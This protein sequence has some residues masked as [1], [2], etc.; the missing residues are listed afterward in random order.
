MCELF[1]ITAERKIRVDGLLKTF[2]N[3]SEKHRN[4]WGLA[5]LDED[6]FSI[7]REPQKAI[8]SPSLRS[9]LKCNVET[10]GCIAHIRKATIGEVTENNTHPFSMRDDFGRQWVLAHNG[11][12]FDSEELAPYQYKQAGT[13]DSE[14]IL[15]YI[16]DQINRQSRIEG[17]ELREEQRIE[18]VEAAIKTIAPGNKVN[19]MIYDGDLLYVHKNEPGT[20]YEKNIDEGVIFSTVPLE[21]DG[22]YEFAQNRLKVYRSGELVYTGKR[23]DYTYI[24]NEE[25]MKLLYFTYSGL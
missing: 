18:T 2:F 15:L 17:H 22:W 25:K 11:T 3:H 7:E 23:H 24:H 4:G 13:T 6:D 12:I 21:S 8:D 14:R 10:S 20:L 5:V 1:G 19:L 9:I 16:V